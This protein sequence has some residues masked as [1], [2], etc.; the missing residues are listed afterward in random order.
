M[1]AKIPR[2][3][4]LYPGLHLGTATR[5]GYLVGHPS[6]ACRIENEAGNSSAKVDSGKQA[7]LINKDAL[8]SVYNVGLNAR[9]RKSFRNVELVPEPDMARY[10]AALTDAA[11][12]ESIQYFGK[13]RA[14]YYFKHPK[15][16][17]LRGEGQITSHVSNLD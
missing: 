2:N 10:H 7:L 9:F 17:V 3:W 15:R 13:G 8:A 4:S 16:E 14:E 12:E 11:L 6:P 1:R 5:S